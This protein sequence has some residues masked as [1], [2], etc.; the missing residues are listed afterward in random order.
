[1]KVDIP[2]RIGDSV[3]AIRNYSG[4][5]KI[6]QGKVSEMYF[7]DESMRLVIVVKHVARGLW[8]KTIFGS[9][10]EAKTYLEEKENEN[11]G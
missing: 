3:W 11:Q 7:M 1:M 6:I 10:E 2:C 9:Y 5:N 8:G 4:Q